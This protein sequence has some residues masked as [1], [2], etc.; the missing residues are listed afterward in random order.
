MWSD[1][2]LVRYAVLCVALIGDGACDFR[3]PP[4]DLMCL[5]DGVFIFVLSSFHHFFPPSFASLS[6][7]RYI[8]LFCLF[9]FLSVLVMAAVPRKETYRNG[10]PAPPT[11]SKS[12]RNF[13]RSCWDRLTQEWVVCTR[14]KE[15][16]DFV[17]WVEVNISFE[18][19]S[20]SHEAVKAMSMRAHAVLCCSAL[21]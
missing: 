6:F 7:S 8:G 10:C 9:E 5:F 14:D 19:Y 18:S 4:P 20:N 17:S 21:L 12:L 11:R 16:F 2:Q 13:A 1:G 3:S 15:T